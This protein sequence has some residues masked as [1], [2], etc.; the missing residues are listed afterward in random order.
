MMTFAFFF[1]MVGT[2]L[3]GTAFILFTLRHH[4]LERKKRRAEETRPR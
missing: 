1:F 2:W 3:F 4:Y